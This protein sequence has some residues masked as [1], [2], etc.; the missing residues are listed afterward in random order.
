MVVVTIGCTTV[1]SDLKAGQVDPVVFNLVTEKA[2][3]HRVP[4][5]L[6]HAV[7]T[8]E[9]MYNPRVRGKRGEYGLGQILCSTAKGLG[10]NGKCE[11]LAEPATN[12]VWTMA[13]LRM[14]LDK[15]KNNECHAA[16]LYA[17]GLD[18]QP[19]N[20][21]YCRNVLRKMAAL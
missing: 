19:G 10:F 8:V 18:H 1:S 3:E 17:A 20:S 12:L 21:S 13:Y 5:K 7:V 16:T 2:K 6:A 4:Y 9:S 11:Q 15:A 14:A